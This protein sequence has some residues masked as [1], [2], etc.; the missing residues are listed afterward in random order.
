MAC[1][2][3]KTQGSSEGLSAI[4]FHFP[5]LHKLFVCKSPSLLYIVVTN[6]VAVIACFLILLLFPVDGFYLESSLPLMSPAGV[7]QGVACSFL[8]SGIAKLG[9]TIPKS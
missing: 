4:F 2:L 7:G 5:G 3:Q 8:F 9:N 6:I 1:G